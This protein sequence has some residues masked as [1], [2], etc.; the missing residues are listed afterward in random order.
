MLLIEKSAVC[1]K[2]RLDAPGLMVASWEQLYTMKSRSRFSYSLS[3]PVAARALARASC[4]A[5]MEAHSAMITETSMNQFLRAP[6]PLVGRAESGSR[7][8]PK[9]NQPN[10]SG[11][12][13]VHLLEAGNNPVARRAVCQRIVGN[14]SH[15]RP[16]LRL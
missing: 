2:K 8:K 10:F 7:V 11:F 16:R 13:L 4:R 12:S 3:A 15:V 6:K 1:L 9:K 14:H 5:L